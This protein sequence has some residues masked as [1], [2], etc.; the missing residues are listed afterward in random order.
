MA[1]THSNS[2]VSLAEQIALLDQPAPGDY[3]PEDV[4][5]TGNHTEDLTSHQGEIHAAAPPGTEHYVDVGPSALRRNLPQSVADPK[6]SA[7]R[8]SR[9]QLL[10]DSNDHPVPDSDGNSEQISLSDTNHESQD[11]DGHSSDEDE[12]NLSDGEPE[13]IPPVSL[14]SAKP[15]SDPPSA[16]TNDLASSLKH[17]RDEDRKKGKAVSRQLALYDGILDARIRLQKC[18]SSANSLPH[19]DRIP[20]FLLTTEARDAADSMLKEAVALSHELCDLRETLMSSNELIQVP[21]RKRRRVKDASDQD[22]E[23]ELQSAG[24]HSALLDSTFHPH[25]LTTLQKWSNKILSIAPSALLPSN[26][27]KFSRANAQTK[28]ATQLIEETLIDHEKL[29]GRTRTYRG[30]GK[31][32]ALDDNPD[33]QEPRQVSG[34]EPQETEIFDDTDF[35]QQLLRDIIDQRSGVTDES[36]WRATQKQKKARKAVDTKA[37]KGRKLRF[38]VHEKLQ[39]FMVP[40][41]PPGVWHEEQI[42]ELFASLLGKGFESRPTANGVTPRDVAV[43]VVDVPPREEPRLDHALTGDFRVFG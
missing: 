41:P 28:S 39:N 5:F 8:V 27:T 43:D 4:A 29:I 18:V 6:Y 19:P 36:D 7:V 21:P 1:A 31:R 34:D 42:D 2:R 14:T 16:T 12:D 9:N 17:T 11:E 38:E 15:P 3:D 13:Q 23:E 22:W 25:L 32:L 35:Y 20:S 10:D 40:V 24:E 33:N 30:K 37:S 26:G